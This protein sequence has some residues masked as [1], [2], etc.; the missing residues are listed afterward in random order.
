MALSAQIARQIVQ[1]L[2]EIAP[3]GFLSTLA[4]G[5]IVKVNKTFLDWTGYSQEEILSSK[6]FQDLL[7]APGKIF[8]E[9]HYAP[10]LHLQGVVKAVAFDLLCKDRKPLPVLV[11][12]VQ[13]SD[14]EGGVPLIHSAF[15]DA[16]DRRKYE[17]DLLR[18]RQRLEEDAVHRTTE[19][20]AEVQERK[21]IADDLRELSGKLLRMRDEE[22][23]RLARELHD[24]VGQLLV[25]L[26]MNQAQILSDPQITPTIEHLVKQ[27]ATFVDHLSAEIRTISHL[28][29]PPLLD[30]VGL[31]SALQVFIEGFSIRSKI[32]VNLEVAADLPR[33]HSEVETTLF[34][35]VQECLTNIYRHSGSEMATVN[36]VAGREQIRLE[37]RDFGSGT[38]PDAL[39]H[40][41]A[42]VGLRGMHERVRQLKGT[43]EISS[44]EPGIRVVAQ[45]PLEGS[46]HGQR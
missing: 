9:T 31:R 8:Y 34:R 42:G 46:S 28:L 7:P 19:L 17:Q 12:S 44:A 14:V 26:N 25:A 11:N 27:N 33:F 18:A 32:N 43:F 3:C 45:I 39:K 41:K 10:L 6:K 36:V 37:V 23:R 20:E 29:H 40:I 35:L 4:D 30:E 2:Y 1:D 24:S 38:A 5:T 16:T 13:N 15:F 22:Q 21:R